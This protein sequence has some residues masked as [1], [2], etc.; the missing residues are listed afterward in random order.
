MKTAGLTLEI[1]EAFAAAKKPLSLSE[2]ARLVDSPVSSCH[3][4]LQNLQKSGYVYA[5]DLRRQ[6]YPT[7]R[8][9]DIGA[10]IAV[11]DPIVDRITPILERLR[12][13]TAETILLGRLQINQIVY[14]NVRESPQTIRYTA[15][16]GA[17]KPLL[18]SAIGK[19]FLGEMLDEELSVFLHTAEHIQVTS[20]TIVDPTQ[21]LA[22]IQRSRKRGYFVTRGEN[23]PDVLAVARTC[24]MGSETIGIAVAGPIH[25]M[26]EKV[27]RIGEAL[28]DET[29]AV[30]SLDAK[31]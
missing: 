3:G 18:S 15:T 19:A 7:R 11:H 2:L 17:I 30:A 31:Y 12:A 20:S 10:E 14:L 1:F 26:E 9:F 6:Y 23:V 27:N 24:K 25:R 21:L 8:L 5:F 16:A 13:K 4:L 29:T 22:D 28:I